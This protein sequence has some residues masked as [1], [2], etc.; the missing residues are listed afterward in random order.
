MTGGEV[1]K[2]KKPGFFD[3]GFSISQSK[4]TL[5]SKSR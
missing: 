3:P 4:K 2:T 1:E 5:K